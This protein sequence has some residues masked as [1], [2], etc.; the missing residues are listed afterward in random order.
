M[1]MVDMISLS[2]LIICLETSNATS[3]SL[4]H[5]DKKY[6]SDIFS[7]VNFVERFGPDYVISKYIIT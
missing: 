5:N 1:D 6:L 4:S 7:F 2:R 3:I